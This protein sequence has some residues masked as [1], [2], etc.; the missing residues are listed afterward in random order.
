MITLNVIDL[1]LSVLD[2]RSKFTNVALKIDKNRQQILLTDARDKYRLL[3][4]SRFALNNR[5]WALTLYQAPV[6]LSLLWLLISIPFRVAAHE[7]RDMGFVRRLRN[8][9][10]G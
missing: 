9:K 1:V 2:C 7:S 10:E 6:P 5:R 4:R 3:E 8:R